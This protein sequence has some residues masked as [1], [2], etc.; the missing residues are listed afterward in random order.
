MLTSMTVCGAISRVIA[1]LTKTDGNVTRG[2]VA[3]QLKSRCGS[4]LESGGRLIAGP[5]AES[6]GPLPDNF[7]KFMLSSGIRA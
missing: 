2:T 6:G 1:I 3:I 5:D 4:D 7:R